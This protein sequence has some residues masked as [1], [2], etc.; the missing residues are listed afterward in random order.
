[1][2]H[3]HCG[4]GID[5]DACCLSF[6][7]VGGNAPTA[8]A[9]MRSR[10][11][12]HVLGNFDYIEKTCAPEAAAEFN[13]MDVERCHEDIE[14]LSLNI[15]QVTGGGVDDETGQV[16]FTFCYRYNGQEQVQ[17]EIATFCRVDGRWLYKDSDINP[18]GKPIV[19]SHIGR[20]DPCPC[21]AGKKYKK[22][23]GT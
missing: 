7:S 8:E 22:C 15:Q 5:L 19:V 10:Y 6:I 16:D 23:C 21:G 2:T 20:N 14:W 18:K 1:M 17:R 13:R 9:L 4:S 12:A 11:T 3:C